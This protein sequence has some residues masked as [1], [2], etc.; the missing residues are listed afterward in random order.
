[1]RRHFEVEKNLR[2]HGSKALRG[3]AKL[4]K[5]QFDASSRSTQLENTRLEIMSK[6]KMRK[7][8]RQL[9]ASTLGSRSLLE[10]TF[11]RNYSRKLSRSK[12]KN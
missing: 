12:S 8:I 2:K 10:E 6:A 4:E 7:K 1:M 3:R 11:G 9:D 5:D